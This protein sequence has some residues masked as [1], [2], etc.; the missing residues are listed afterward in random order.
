[1][2]AFI[3]NVELDRCVNNGISESSDISTYRLE[4]INKTTI[5][6]H[7]TNSPLT[8]SINC[9]LENEER[10]ERFEKLLQYKREGEVVQFNFDDSHEN[11][12]ITNISKNIN[13][14]NVIDLTI[15]FLQVS[16][17]Q[18]KRTPTPLDSIGIRPDSTNTKIGRQGTVPLIGGD[19]DN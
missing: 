15:D 4:N 17:S 11:L 14:L 10:F 1:M 6:D 2:K 18:I 13:S 7:I 3:N 8:F 12:L 16:F 9:T 5:T 19:V